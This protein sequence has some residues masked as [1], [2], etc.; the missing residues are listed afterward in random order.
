MHVEQ[1]NLHLEPWA[2]KE[3]LVHIFDS[4]KCCSWNFLFI[5]GSDY[6]VDQQIEM[7]ADI[8]NH[9]NSNS[10]SCHQRKV[11]VMLTSN[12]G[13]KELALQLYEEVQVTGSRTTLSI[14]RFQETLHQITSP[15][16][17]ALKERKVPFTPVP[18]L[19]LGKAEVERCILH[20]MKLKKKPAS[21]QVLNSIISDIRFVPPRLEYFAA[22]GCKSVSNQVNLHS[23]S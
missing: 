12:Y 13:Q 23:Q 16:I 17:A 3:K 2:S 6:A 11:V 14:T 9:I 8:L 21:Q 18:Y 4:I 22:S 5:E 1:M 7:L 19:P 20:D 15:L 10:S